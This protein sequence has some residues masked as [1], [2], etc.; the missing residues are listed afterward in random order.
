MLKDTSRIEYKMDGYVELIARSAVAV[1]GV[2]LFTWGFLK[3]KG[4]IDEQIS[5]LTVEH[6]DLRVICNGLT[7]KLSV[8]EKS[9]EACQTAQE[10]LSKKQ[11][12]L[13]ELITESYLSG[14]D[15]TK[16][17]EVREFQ[18]NTMGHRPSLYPLK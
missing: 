10:T 4:G 17:E 12:E 8:L 15:G 9:I 1:V 16:I 11:A 5:M 3:V 13:K 2:G 18:K 7:N 6:F 14:A